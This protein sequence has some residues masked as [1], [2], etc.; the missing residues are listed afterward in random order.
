MNKSGEIGLRR[1]ANRSEVRPRTAEQGPRWRGCAPDPV[2]EAPV[3]EGALKAAI[4]ICETG[5]NASAPAN[6]PAA[7][8]SQ[9]HPVAGMPSHW[10]KCGLAHTYAVA[11]PKGPLFR[12]PARAP[13]KIC[14]DARFATKYEDNSRHLCLPLTVPLTVPLIV[15]HYASMPA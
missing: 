15:K 8:G 5:R 11:S 6:E 1:G 14:N 7:N 10:D 13:R 4:D 3:R 2:R 12:A 9:P